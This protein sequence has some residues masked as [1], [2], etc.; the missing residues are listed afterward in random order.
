MRISVIGA[1]HVGLVA[2]VGLAEIGHEVVCVDND[3]AKMEGLRAGH[4]PFFEP[5]LQELLEAN[6]GRGGVRFSTDLSDAVDHAEV[7]FLCVG[8][9]PL[10]GGE[11]DLSAV[12]RVTRQI[13]TLAE[14]YKL[15]VEKSTVPVLTGERI[16]KTMHT[17][18]RVRGPTEFAVASN[19]EFLSEG[20]AVQDF[21]FPDRIVIGVESDRAESL[22]REVYAPIVE[23]SFA[24]RPDPPPER[25]EALTPML[26]TNR[27]TAEIIKHASNSFLATKISYINMVARLCDEVGADIGRVAEGMGLD[28]RIGP[29][30][31]RAGLGFGGFCFPK[32]LQAFVAMAERSGCDFSLLKEVEAL[33]RRC[34]TEFLSK[35]K[36][37]LWVLKGKSIGVWGLAFKAHTDDM[38]FSQAAAVVE[39][40]LREGATIRAYD[41]RAIEEAR[42]MLPEVEFAESAERASVGCDA[43][44]VLTEWPEFK[45]ADLEQV[46]DNMVRPLVVDGRNLF[47]PAHMRSLGFEYV[48]IGRP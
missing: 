4:T 23:Q 46:R 35:L 40:L 8:T 20:T 5:Y 36:K 28:H 38:R 10:P 7:I 44:V 43:L 27:S 32:D 3:T 21:L 24:W 15:V 13:A 1:G 19:P 18:S 33:N 6:S 11:A 2:G 37:E 9:P 30:F 34:A 41:P 16:Y 45:Q 26:V 25:R 39:E 31:L 42:K 22:L 12:E 14:G 48:S 47:D 29:H 17:Y